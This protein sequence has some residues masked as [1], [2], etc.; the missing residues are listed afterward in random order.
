MAISLFFASPIKASIRKNFSIYMNLCD[1]YV[2]RVRISCFGSKS[3]SKPLQWFIAEPGIGKTEKKQSMKKILYDGGYDGYGIENWARGSRYKGQYR[4]RLRHG[5]GV[6]KFYMGDTNAGE[7]C[8]GQ[9]NGIGEQICAD[10]ISYIGEF[11]GGV[12]HGLGCYHFRNGDRY[13]GE[14]FGDKMH[15]FGV[16]QFANGHLYEGS[17]HEGGKQGYGMYTFRN[18]TRILNCATTN[19]S[20]NA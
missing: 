18:G 11:K 13:T 12:K 20:R 17:W 5:Y 15:G 8:N 2:G 4:Q 9:S 14:Y 7:W 19:R 6:Y 10:G 3:P 16:Y 1:D